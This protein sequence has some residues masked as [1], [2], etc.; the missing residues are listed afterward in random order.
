MPGLLVNTAAPGTGA[1]HHP[2]SNWE[3]R[4]SRWRNK[5]V[6][7]DKPTRAPRQLRWPLRGSL[8]GLDPAGLSAG[9]TV[10]SIVRWDERQWR[11]G[12]SHA[13]F[14]ITGLT[15]NSADAA[16][17]GCTLKLYQTAGHGHHYGIDPLGPGS[18]KDSLIQET[19]SADSGDA[20]E[21]GRYSFGVW[22]N[23]TQYYIVAQ[24]TDGTLVGTTVKTLVGS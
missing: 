3:V 2:T 8:T 15:K 12:H 11:S 13:P 10:D 7:S 19:T 4:N 9:Y 22:D 23:T 1:K 24:N 6:V 5:C 16:I 21:L 18:P 14:R 17:G 20:L